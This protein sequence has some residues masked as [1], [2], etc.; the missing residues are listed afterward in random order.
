MPRQLTREALYELVWSKPKT[1]LAKELGVSAVALGKACARA[2]VP[3]PPSGYWAAR[4]VATRVRKIPLPPRGLGE[5]DSVE[6]GRSVTW[7]YNEPA[8]D[9]PAPPEF[10]EPLE[11]IIERAKKQVG[12]ASVTRSL[13]KPHPLVGRLLEED[14]E[15]R[16]RATAARYPFQGPKF[17]APPAKR[18]LRLINALFLALSRAKCHPYCRGDEAEELGAKV[19]HQYIAFSVVPAKRSR[20]ADRLFG[21][22]DTKA[23]LP[24]RITVAA[25]C[26]CPAGLKTEWQDS[27]GS[28]LEDRLQDIA[29]HILVF[30]ELQYRARVLEHYEWRTEQKRR[31]DEAARAARERAEQE[32]REALLRQEAARRDRLIMQAQNWQRAADIRALVSAV[33]NHSEAKL[34]PEELERW[35]AWALSQA[36]AI[37]VTRGP[38]PRL[39]NAEAGDVRLDSDP[40]Y[41]QSVPESNETGRRIGIAKGAFEMSE[42]PSYPRDP[43]WEAMPEVGREVWPT[44]SGDDAAWTTGHT[45]AHRDRAVVKLDRDNQPLDDNERS[46]LLD[47]IGVEARA[48]YSLVLQFENGE[49]RVFDMT[50]LL[51][52]PPYTGLRGP[53]F[54]LAMVRNGTVMWPGD[55]DIA[56]ETLY[57]HSVRTKK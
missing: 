32:R 21:P 47:V 15:R 3:V 11:V 54:K 16:K 39:L 7:H 19:G 20:R 13:E 31:H 50:P 34:H 38:L 25:D 22:D 46:E 10:P 51:D 8:G 26:Q 43:S 56:P 33:R 35:V 1:A 41:R 6:I 53:L 18:R 17:D 44:Y 4:A 49:F 57:D 40:I 28:S 23:R 52:R 5:S 9:L 45:Q 14:E 30:G 12:K 55:I 36:D 2:L 48:D 29:V 27:E 42:E 37:D 24:L